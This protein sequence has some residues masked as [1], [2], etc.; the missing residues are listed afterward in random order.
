MFCKVSKTIWFVLLAV[1]MMSV[2][3]PVHAKVTAEEAARLKTALT[4]IGAERAGNADGTIPA[5]EGG[6]TSIPANVNFDS[7]KPHPDPFA[8]DKILFT[9]TAQNLDQYA[10][11]LS[12]GIK[13][14]FKKY[15]DTW[16]MNV[17][18]TRR[19]VGYAQ[20][21]YENAYLNAVEAELIGDGSKGFTGAFGAIPFPIPGNGAEAVLNHIYRVLP[22]MFIEYF[23]NYLVYPNGKYSR[24]S[25][26]KNTTRIQYMEGK[27]E[28]YDS[29]HFSQSV[30]IEYYE[31]A[32][33][34]GEILL[35]R[36][37]LDFRK[38]ERGA[39]QYFPGQRR[40]RRAPS[41][42]YDTPNP[43]FGGYGFY[44]ETFIYNGK[45]D[46]YDWKLSGKQEMFVP[47]NNYQVDLVPLDELLTPRHPNPEY[48]RW[49]LHRMWVNEG[50]VKKDQR[51]AYGKRVF[52]QDEDS[53]I[54]TLADC[55]DLQGALWRTRFQ[56][57]K[58]YYDQPMLRT[59]IATLIDFQVD[60]YV[61]A[62]IIHGVPALTE[63]TRVPEEW[64]TAQSVR[65]RGRR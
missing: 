65:K 44:D 17:Y 9:I 57:S 2:A 43:A 8:D 10:D 7:K 63:Y 38:N 31:P 51:H 35:V 45:I 61:Q 49:E 4:P 32:R 30:L 37:R 59:R 16:K 27:R 22:E 26:Q 34:K 29:D 3:M 41:V 11:K 12:P 20:S 53:W 64:M 46:R 18:P 28:D 62:E 60:A 13:A 21:V 1:C 14:L 25:G 36:D 55:Y 58:H 56:T 47:Y 19:T 40:V 23:S 24:T 33:R 52:Y 39:W 15:P 48:I 50:T 5:W 42:A 6:L 54:V